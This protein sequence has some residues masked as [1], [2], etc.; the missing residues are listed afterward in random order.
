M[1]R[2]YFFVL[3]T[4]S[5]TSAAGDNLIFENFKLSKSCISPD[6]VAYVKHPQANKSDLSAR[7][8]GA[9]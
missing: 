6:I 3:E 1:M 2:T 4:A 7:P 8:F 5:P 9:R